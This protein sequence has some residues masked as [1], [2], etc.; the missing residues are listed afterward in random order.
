MARKLA[1]IDSLTTLFDSSSRPIYAIDAERQIVYCNRALATWLGMEPRRII[2]RLVEY[3]SEPAT[4]KGE[5]PEDMPLADLCPPPRAIAG[6]S[7]MGALSCLAR[8]G[9]LVHRRAEYMPLGDFGREQSNRDKS[10]PA[11]Q[12]YAVLVILSAADMSTQEVASQPTAE[13]A[14]DELHRTIRRF[15]RG[16]ANRYSIASLLGESAGMQ[17]VRAQVA[18]AATSGANTLICGARGSGRGHVAR[19]I[20]FGGVND[21]SAKLLPIDCELL[22]DDR[23]RRVIDNLRALPG[24][25]IQR[26]TLLLENLESM[27]A[28]HRSLLLAAIRQDLFSA[29]IIATCRR[30]SEE[31][32][33]D[34]IRETLDAEPRA[35]E[36]VAEPA[37]TDSALVNII[38]TITIDLP[39]LTD[40]VEDLAVVAQ[41]FLESCNQ[42]SGK[43]V[44]SLR[45]DALD[46]LA[47]YNWPG[48]SE[49]LR[50]TIAAAHRACTSHEI[51]PADLPGIIRHAS[52]AAAHVRR[53]PERIVLDELLAT[54]EKEA[55]VRALAESGG[56]KSEAAAL[57]G[58][59][60]PRLY[61]RLIQLGLAG[62]ESDDLQR[63]QPEF[64]ERDSSE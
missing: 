17:K 18:A 23:L 8:D 16:Q 37:T 27:S 31:I 33:R 50:D 44:G 45:A 34:R 6:E 63:E 49:Q 24:D 13:P 21:A 11:P 59:T 19:A 60:R 48:D 53:P 30:T 35:G 55:I 41:Y 15:R 40:R 1:N 64:I 61:R 46:L 42:G 28:P 47:L 51:T 7:C 5:T 14:V 62:D 43:Q 4:G 52:R 38:S 22:T 29:R 20:Y 10:Q 9:R 39:P 32:N 36:N 54:I 56:N 2:G 25:A 3:H 26:P 57:L 12:R 58:M